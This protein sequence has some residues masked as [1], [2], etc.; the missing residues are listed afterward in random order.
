MPIIIVLSSCVAWDAVIHNSFA[1]A[2]AAAWVDPDFKLRALIPPSDKTLTLS[3]GNAL[4]V[5][6]VWITAYPSLTFETKP[7]KAAAF[8]G[9]IKTPSTGLLLITN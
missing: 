5:P 4:F 2:P 9:S 7:K 1:A 8:V 6:V 3:V